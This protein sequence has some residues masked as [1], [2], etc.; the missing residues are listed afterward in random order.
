ML[1]NMGPQIFTGD[2]FSAL[3]QALD[4]AALR[5]EAVAADLAN[6]TEPS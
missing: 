5:H 6:A 2:T 4:A 3:T 1:A